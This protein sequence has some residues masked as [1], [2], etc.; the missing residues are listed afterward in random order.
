MK[1]QHVDCTISFS[2]FAGISGGLTVACVQCVLLEGLVHLS[3]TCTLC[4]A[5]PP[6]S[7]HLLIS[8]GQSGV[9]RVRSTCRVFGSGTAQ[10][11]PN[12]VSRHIWFRATRVSVGR[13]TESPGRGCV[14][15]SSN[16]DI[17]Q[18]IPN[19]PEAGRQAANLDTHHLPPLSLWT[20][21]RASPRPRP[22][23]DKRGEHPRD[24][25]SR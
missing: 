8:P 21:S 25:V 10:A 5:I 12:G 3:A 20:G 19:P 15:C 14:G 7:P 23:L 17:C 22:L 16:P 18:S 11:R 2:H 1:L 24:L 13:Q 6:P 4:A 9:T